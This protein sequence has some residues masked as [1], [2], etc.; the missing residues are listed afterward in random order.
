MKNANCIITLFLSLSSI[1]AQAN[2]ITITP[3]SSTVVQP[4]N[5]PVTVMCTGNTEILEKFC[6]CLDPGPNFMKR[7]KKSYVMSN[8]EIRNLYLGDYTNLQSCDEAKATSDAC[9][10]SDTNLE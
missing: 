1:I 10:N 2:P 5:Q 6:V 7:L 9:K 3:G 4:S 8:G